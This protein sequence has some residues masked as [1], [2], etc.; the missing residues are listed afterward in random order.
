VNADRIPASIALVASSAMRPSTTSLTTASWHS[1][2]SVDV[3]QRCSGW[4][5]DVRPRLMR[6]IVA[7]HPGLM[8]KQV[9]LA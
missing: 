6:A 8:T 5:K 4:R 7:Q 3:D 2:G 1:H 9:P